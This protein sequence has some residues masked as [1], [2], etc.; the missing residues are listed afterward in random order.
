MKLPPKIMDRKV[1][2]EHQVCYLYLHDPL[3]QWFTCQK[4][5]IASVWINK[6]ILYCLAAKNVTELKISGHCF[7]SKSNKIGIAKHI[8]CIFLLQTI[9]AQSNTDS[10]FERVSSLSH[11]DLTQAKT[12]Y[13]LGLAAMQKW[14]ELIS[15]V[16]FLFSFV[17]FVLP[18]VNKQNV[19]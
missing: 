13:A 4:L 14:V 3:L 2:S 8:Q 19:N 1:R 12:C 15:K 5:Y 6:Y 7:S 16:T 18:P 17:L 9:Q 10:W 11:G